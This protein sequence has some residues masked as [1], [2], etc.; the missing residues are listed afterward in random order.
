MIIREARNQDAEAIC[1]LIQELGEA[2]RFASPL[3]PA[4]V[5]RFLEHPGCGALLAEDE[6]R[7]IGLLSY[8]SRPNLLHGA[9]ACLIEELIVHREHRDRGVGSTLLRELL[10]RARDAGCAEVAV[11]VMPENRGAQRFYREHGL[12]DEVLTLE[13][14]FPPGS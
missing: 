12:V 7:V 10:R 2:E 5:P 8:L 13:L 1:G 4:Y 11:G 9:G 6:G 14:H 3:T